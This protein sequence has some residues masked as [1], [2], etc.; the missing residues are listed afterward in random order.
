MAP[1]EDKK[2]ILIVDDEPRM[3]QFIRMN[4]EL[5]GYRV[6]EADRGMVALDKVRQE[7]PDLVVLDVMMPEMDG[8]E[9][10]RLIRE[11]SSVPVIMLTVRAGTGCRRLRYQTVQPA[12]AIQPYQGGLAPG[13]GAGHQRPGHRQSG[14]LPFY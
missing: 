11:V 3:R 5:E 1:E 14:R 2:L 6:S 8:F 12:R 10:L 13:R 4:L 7:L 9:T